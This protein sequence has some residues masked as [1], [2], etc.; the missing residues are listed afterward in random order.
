MFNWHN[1]HYIRMIIPYIFGVFTALYLVDDANQGLLL[2]IPAFILVPVYFFTR[3]KPQKY[4]LD[5]LYGI[6]LFTLLFAL[7]SFRQLN[8]NELNS[9]NHFTKNDNSAFLLTQVN[10]EPYDRENFVRVKLKVKGTIDSVGQ[11]VKSAGSVLAYFRK[12]V[13]QNLRI[14][15]EIIIHA[16]NIQEVP[17]PR[18]P[19]E[20]DYKRF[21]SYQNIYY[22]VFLNETDWKTTGSFQNSVT[23][24][25][26]GVRQSIIA[27]IGE[28]FP[29][30]EHKGFAEAL[31]VGYRNNLNTEIVDSFSKT[32]TLHVLAV[33][34]LH[35]GIIFL[36]LS[37]LGKVFSNFRYE[38]ILKSMLVIV[39][40]WA[41]A[42]VTG[43]SPSVQ[44]AAIMF[45]VVQLSVI[46]KRKP[47]I[48]NSIFASAFLILLV[49]PLLIVS[50][51]FQLSYTAVLGIVY[52]QPKIRH[53]YLPKTKVTKYIWELIA[54][55]LAAQIATFPLGIFYFYQFPLYFLLSNLVVIPVIFIVMLALITSVSFFWIPI[56]G[57][58]I[59]WVTSLSI[60]FILWTVRTMQAL[61]YSSFEHLYITPLQLVLIYLF[62][63]GLTMWL[64]SARKSYLYVTMCVLLLFMSTA[65]FRIYKINHQD[66]AVL[67]S[68]NKHRV[69]SVVKGREVHFIA[70]AEFL[71][72]EYSQR[73]YLRPYIAENGL[74]KIY[75]H[76][77][78]DSVSAS[79]FRLTDN[80]LYLQKHI[81]IHKK[82]WLFH[83]QFSSE[84]YTALIFEHW[85]LKR[86]RY[87]AQ[88]E[89]E[90]KEVTHWLRFE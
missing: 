10:E 76:T 16:E 77:W 68:I 5:V 67:H 87:L 30:T 39:G 88:R 1:I 48:Y 25:A 13:E 58:V 51:S 89:L 23:R 37:N 55:S 32:G 27:T 41:Y 42:F 31:L 83:H 38:S 14:G 11:I 12:P 34:G 26:S 36:I 85:N 79:N 7:G 78:N 47:N 33:S 22:Q 82:D 17:T 64:Y 40:I 74:R 24:V 70:D 2:F 63:L 72:D 56:L 66:F 15:D 18:N 57:S 90:I 3:K 80:A 20:F 45:S 21:L 61:P 46:F 71:N 65:V 53:W 44:R 69:M 9:P 84:K 50:V 54:V 62:I 73:F 81:L 49:N 28:L 86:L 6:A 35:V 29:K 52:F 75:F 60:E 4:S 43:M 19:G 8:Y 59:V